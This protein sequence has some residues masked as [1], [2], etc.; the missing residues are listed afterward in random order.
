MNLDVLGVIFSVLVGAFISNIP[1]AKKFQVEY[2][3]VSRC[4]F[5]ILFFA[6]GSITH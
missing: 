5:L 4:N 2:S 1:I 6:G 3:R